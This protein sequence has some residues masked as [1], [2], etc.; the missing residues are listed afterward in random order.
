[1]SLTHIRAALESRLGTVTP[2]IS[3]AYE[4]VAFVPVMDA[5]YQR[6]HLL[7]AMPQNP[8]M[9]RSFHRDIG[10]FQVMLCYPLQ[11]GAGAAEAQAELIRT[12]FSRGTTL[13]H[14]DVTVCIDR[15]PQITALPNEDERFIVVVRIQYRA[16]IF[17]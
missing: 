11:T 12:A 9:G 5:P 16:D 14:G 6:A 10:M 1:M 4:N 13:T 2:V 8:T 15:T 7:P 3:T 17:E